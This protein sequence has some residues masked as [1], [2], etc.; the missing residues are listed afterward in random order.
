MQL[1]ASVLIV[2]FVFWLIFRIEKR[3]ANMIRNKIF[4]NFPNIKD[5]LDNFQHKLDYLTSQME[6][7]QR[8]VSALEDKM[9]K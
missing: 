1:V 3:V 2:L 7:L 6:F 9:Q 4:E 5:Q 8:K